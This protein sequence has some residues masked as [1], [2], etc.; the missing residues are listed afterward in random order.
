MMYF[1]WTVVLASAVLGAWVT[2]DRL[3]FV[4]RAEP[5]T[6]TVVGFTE[7]I[8][9]DDDRKPTTMYSPQI[10]FDAPNGETITYRPNSSSSRP[11]YEVGEKIDMLYDPANPANAV[12]DSW[13]Q[14]WFGSV[15]AAI[16]ILA[17]GGSAMLMSYLGRNSAGLGRSRRRAGGGGGQDH[18]T[19]ESGASTVGTG[20][21]DETAWIITEHG[22]SERTGN[23]NDDRWITPEDG[24]AE[25]GDGEGRWTE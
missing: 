17:F 11:G 1:F 13:W 3:Q 9:R 16:L 23:V 21:S 19:D 20:D 25:R 4:A 22:E 6:G 8:K 18:E 7:T 12:I 14:K 15:I 24:D 2:Y 10:T 5:V